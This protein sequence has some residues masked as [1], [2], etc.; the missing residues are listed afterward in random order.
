[1]RSIHFPAGCAERRSARSC[2]NEAPPWFPFGG[3][4]T[5]AE[6]ESAGMEG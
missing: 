5:F 1:M 6:G 3:H 4:P 2:R